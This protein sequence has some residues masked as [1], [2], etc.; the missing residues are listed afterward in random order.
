MDF[1]TSFRERAQQAVNAAT[2][3][4]TPVLAEASQAVKAMAETVASD[5]QTVA[6]DA[7]T[8]ARGLT[9]EVKEPSRPRL[10]D[11]GITDQ[12]LAVVR[13]LTY[14]SFD[15]DSDLG[16]SD[17][18]SMEP[19]QVEHATAILVE[20]PELD[21]LRFTL[22]PKRMSE[23]QFWAVYFELVDKSLVHDTKSESSEDQGGCGGR[24][25]PDRVSNAARSGLSAWE[26]V[27]H[28]DATSR[29]NS[30]SAAADN[31][32]DDLDAYLK[33]MLDGD[34]DDAHEGVSEAADDIDEYLKE[35]GGSDDSAEGAAG[36]DGAEGVGPCDD[37]DLDAYLGDLE[38][39]GDEGAAA[40]DE[41]VP[42]D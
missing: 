6:A 5:V 36:G 22:C 14:A 10:R 19:W 17:A 29:P 40:Q 4:A 11:V 8:K 20:C 23:A 27:Q 28:E 42:S 13:S 16:I 12:V 32:G 2:E 30:S 21:S 35:L 37:D 33:G 24:Q 7:R 31:A 15:R 41:D 3:L 25:S 9:D 34:G 39:S 38:L 18:P 26:A 1:F